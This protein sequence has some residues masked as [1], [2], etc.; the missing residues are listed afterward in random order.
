MLSFLLTFFLSF[1]PTPADQITS[2]WGLAIA[3]VTD[4]ADTTNISESS[5]VD[6][7]VVPG[8]SP[9]SLTAKRA[10]KPQLAKPVRKAKVA[11]GMSTSAI[12]AT[13]SLLFNLDPNSFGGIGLGS[14]S[15]ARLGADAVVAKVQA[16]YK[17]TETL[18]A[19]FRQTVT[20][21][22]FGRKSI[23][24]GYVWIKKPGKMRWDY[25]SKKKPVQV[26]KSFISDGQTLW[27]VFHQDMQ[28]FKQS[29][30][31]NLLPVAITFL[32]GKGDLSTDFIAAIDTRSGYGAKGDY[33]VKLTPR[34]PN[35]QYKTL[36]LVVDP[37]NY[38]VKQS[39]V[40]NSKGDTNQFAFYEG[41]TKATVKDSFFVFN[42]KANKKFRLIN[43]DKAPT[44]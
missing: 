4:S 16:F 10:N 8:T 26:T 44:K 42:E 12:L 33:V 6:V 2:A 27:A 43:P 7:P 13:K 32:A 20:N 15:P 19:K 11:S 34:K 22:T 29:T 30:K 39:V 38:R 36:W 3:S 35:A 21:A 37:S 23:S 25:Y 1:S 9:I 5:D 31:D 28:F 41:D 18:R 14:V 40:L 17:D 24:D